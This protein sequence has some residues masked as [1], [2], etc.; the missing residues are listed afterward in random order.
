M[1]SRKERKLTTITMT[2]LFGVRVNLDRLLM[3][4][5][6]AATFNKGAVTTSATTTKTA[7][8]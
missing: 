8:C 1:S 3:V 2:H 4:L 7:S 6:A 5:T